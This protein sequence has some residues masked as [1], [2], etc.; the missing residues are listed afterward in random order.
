MLLSQKH[1]VLRQF[2]CIFRP[3]GRHLEFRRHFELFSMGLYQDLLSVKNA[4]CV[5]IFMLLSQKHTV[6]RQFNCIFRPSGRHLEF[7]HHFELFWVGP[8]PDL[9]SSKNATFVPSFML[10]PENPHSF[11]QFAGLYYANYWYM[12]LNEPICRWGF[13]D[14]NS[15][16]GCSGFQDDLFSKA[17]YSLTAENNKNLADCQFHDGTIHPK[18]TSETSHSLSPS[19]YDDR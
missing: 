18:I 15:H 1:A 10:L 9:L 3:S 19:Q 13:V 4:L 14:M 5:P 8:Y 16:F 7:C 11:H 6:L 2:N 17:S 12:D